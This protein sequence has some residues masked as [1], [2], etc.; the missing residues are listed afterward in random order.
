[1][2]QPARMQLERPIGFIARGAQPNKV[3][4]LDDEHSENGFCIELKREGGGWS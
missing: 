3:L 2:S 4:C 1:M